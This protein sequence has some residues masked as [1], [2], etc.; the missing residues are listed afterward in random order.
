[1]LQIYLPSST[2]LKLCSDVPTVDFVDTWTF[3]TIF[4]SRYLGPNIWVLANRSKM[5]CQPLGHLLG[6]VK[7]LH[8]GTL[9]SGPGTMVPQTWYP[10]VQDS[11][12]RYPVLG[13]QHLG[14]FIWYL[15][16]GTQGPVKCLCSRFYFVL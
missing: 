4:M 2:D 11:R 3:V 6:P 5:I 7:C 1:M 14:P 15:V 9:H 8:L 10:K 12:V 16:P 13:T